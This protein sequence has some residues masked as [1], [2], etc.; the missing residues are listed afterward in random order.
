[1]EHAQKTF[2]LSVP[3]DT[4]NLA[5]IREFLDRTARRSPI[6]DQDLERLKLAVNE[7]C[8]NVIKHAYGNDMT[9]DLTLHVWLDDVQIAVDVID[10]GHSFDPMSHKP[11]ELD[12]LIGR[13]GG[14]GIRLMR[15]ATDELIADIDE[16]G[17]NRLR[18]VKRFESSETDET[19][20]PS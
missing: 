4:E 11:L 8:E 13:K 19:D 16:S 9:R 12:E 7:A 14:M 20:S 1:V 6:S 5:M 10:S 15:L 18:L 17:H 3:S 2:K